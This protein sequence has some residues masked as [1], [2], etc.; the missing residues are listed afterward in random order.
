MCPVCPDFLVVLV[1]ATYK[2]RLLLQKT[3]DAKA[4][5]ERM[6]LDRG[7]RHP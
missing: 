6:H 3:G 7:A 2:H 4:G 5:K 1:R